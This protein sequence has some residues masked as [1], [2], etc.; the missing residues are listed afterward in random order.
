MLRPLGQIW[1]RPDPTTAPRRPLQASEPSP[2]AQPASSA[3][4]RVASRT[5][6][7]EAPA[8]K[9]EFRGAWIATVQNIDWPSSPGLSVAAQQAELVAMLDKAQ[10][11]GL[12]AVVLQV[13]P[14]CDAFYKSPFEPSAP[15]LTGTMGQDPGYDPLAFA[16]EEAHKRGLELHAWFNPFRAGNVNDPVSADHVTRK[17]PEW[18]QHYG[19]HLWLDPA[20]PQ[21]Q[22]YAQQVILDVVKRYDID[23]VHM[24]DYFYPYKFSQNGQVVD[25]PDQKE[26]QAY[27]SAG[28]KLELADWRRDNINRFV[29]GL[30][31]LVHQEKP[32]LQLGISPFGIWKPGNPPGIKGMS[33]FD[34]LYADSAKWL[35]QGWVDYLAPQLYWPI[36][37]PAQSFGAL[38]KWWSEQ[39]PLNRHLY[40]GLATSSVSSGWK[41]DEITRQIDLARQTAGAEGHIHFSMKPLNTNANGIDQA[42]ATPYHEPALAPA[43][44]WLGSTPPDAPSATL[45]TNAATGGRTVSWKPADGAD[46]FRWVVYARTNGQWLPTLYPAGKRALIL[47]A[48]APDALEIAAVD[49]TGNESQRARLDIPPRA[50]KSLS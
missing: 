11:L 21:V 23:A 38:L 32:K 50:A 1:G 40:A 41:A 3:D 27:Q 20:N 36:E 45:A 22:A 48:Q 28:G 18:V 10:T 46:V 26:F 8:A 12:N 9:R 43:S 19:P 6:S 35:Q 39:N 24:D 29:T 42:L 15:E 44:P 13:R 49:R 5:V 31:F 14:N 16:V 25:F 30:D 2:A 17:H 4:Q 33:A 37:K 7:G 47:G 34:E